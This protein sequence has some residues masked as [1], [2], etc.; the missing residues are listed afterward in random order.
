MKKIPLNT[1]SI[2][3]DYGL[4]SYLDDQLAPRTSFC[5]KLSKEAIMKWQSSEISQPLLK[6]LNSDFKETALS[7]FNRKSALLDLI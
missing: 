3:K 4:N 2:L 6:L 7:M 1:I 5:R